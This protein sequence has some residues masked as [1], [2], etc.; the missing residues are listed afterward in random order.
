MAIK[1]V[2]DLILKTAAKEFLGYGFSGTRM[3]TIADKA[4]INKA[5]LH[6]HFSSKEELYHKILK[7]H[8]EGLISSMLEIFESDEEFEPWLRRVIS[9]LV[10]ETA[11]KPHLSRFLIWELSSSATHLPRLFIEMLA[12][13]SD[14]LIPQRI[15]SKLQQAGLRDYPAH[16]V[17]F[18]L[19]ALCIYPSMARPLLEQILG[20][21]VYSSK[22]FIAQREE[23]IFELI[24]HGILLRKRGEA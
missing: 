7:A 15:A 5:L 19:H 2:K 24:K 23:E 17:L 14:T 1:N 3:Q 12:E 11:T 8:F 21:K 13:R 4:G 16:Q 18:N 22:D 9:R 20:K 6:Y 10:N